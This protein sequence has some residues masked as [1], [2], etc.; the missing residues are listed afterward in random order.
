MKRDYEIN[1][2]NEIN[3]KIHGFRLFRNPSSF[4]FNCDQPVHSFNVELFGFAIRP[5][6]FK[7]INFRGRSQ[8]EMDA[9]I[10][11]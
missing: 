6:H 3:E 2:N 5:A 4:L 11:L 1:E 7:T 8:P 9:K 10:G